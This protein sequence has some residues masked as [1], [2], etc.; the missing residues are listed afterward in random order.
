MWLGVCILLLFVFLLVQ[1]AHAQPNL[2]DSTAVKIYVDGLNRAIDAA[3]VHKNISFLQQHYAA[4]FHFI[5]GTGQLDSKSSWIAFV[6]NPLHNTC[7]GGT[8][9]QQ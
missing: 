5:H 3:V 8:I 1:A 2:K 6:R 4:D 9:P 7:T